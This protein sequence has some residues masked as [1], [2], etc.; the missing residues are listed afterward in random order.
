VIG[1][2]VLFM[3][4]FIFS[5]GAW[6]YLLKSDINNMWTCVCMSVLTFIGAVICLCI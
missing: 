6:A 1:A 5:A 3:G 2:L 4:T